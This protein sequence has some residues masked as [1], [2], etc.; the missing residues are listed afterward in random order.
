LQPTR[1]I[2]RSNYAACSAHHLSQR[3]RETADL[4]SF[5]EVETTLTQVG[6]NGDA[7]F[8][9]THDPPRPPKAPRAYTLPGWH[10]MGKM[11]VHATVVTGLEETLPLSTAAVTDPP[12][13]LHPVSRGRKVA[14][15]A[16]K[17]SLAGYLCPQAQPVTPFSCQ[18]PARISAFMDCLVIS[19]TRWP[20]IAEP[21]LPYFNF[22][23]ANFD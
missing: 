22:Q 17:G 16:F 4:E 7:R 12:P 9:L 20:G 13:G 11:P 14:T 21:W 15:N 8:D 2:L 5:G 18:L 10:M 1:G 6:S 3:T 23:A 19:G